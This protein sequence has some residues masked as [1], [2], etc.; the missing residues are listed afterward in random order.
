MIHDENEFLLL[1]RQ[2]MKQTTVH[3]HRRAARIA[4]TM[5]YDDPPT[6]VH[7]LVKA[8][9]L[10]RKERA[11]SIILHYTHEQRFAHYKRA[12]HQMWD[13]TF[14]NKPLHSTTLTVGTRNNPNLGKELVYRNPLSKNGRRNTSRPTNH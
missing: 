1:R 11:K 8:K 7:P 3:E 14:H 13:D 12:I 6:N 5:D 2:L 4:R 10:K 9:L